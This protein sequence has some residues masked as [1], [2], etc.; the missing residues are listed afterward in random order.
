M[1]AEGATL[2]L[3]AAEQTFARAMAAPEPTDPEAPAPP[4]RAELSEAERGA[5]Y[6]YTT[7][8][9][10]TQR[11]KKAPGRPRKTPARVTEA[12]AA[13]A[14]APAKPG[15]VPDY[16]GQLAGLTEAVWMVLAAAPAPTFAARVK[17]RAQAKVLRD[18]QAPLVQGLN[19]CAQNNSVIRRG[20]EALTA[21]GAGWVL[22]AVMA[23]APFAV[24]SSA[25][26]R[27]DP[28]QLALMAAETE[29]EWSAQ[30]AAMQAAMFPPEPDGD[31]HQAD[32]PVPAGARM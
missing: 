11:P 16:T 13:A 1:T 30:F 5:K 24:Q 23:V 2:E 31:E 4:K 20:V 17:L 9:D 18:N 15:K 32:D 25:L 28:S 8:K 29:A 22:P 6:G 10:G 27:A 7:D 26:W 21:G 14:E 19:L 12:P 3:D